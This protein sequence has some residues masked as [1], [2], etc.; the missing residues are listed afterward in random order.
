MIVKRY[1]VQLIITGSSRMKEVSNIVGSV[2]E[3]LAL[4]ALDIDLI[5]EMLNLLNSPWL[6]SVNGFKIFSY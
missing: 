2:I 3:I 6:S 5:S 4:I 1:E